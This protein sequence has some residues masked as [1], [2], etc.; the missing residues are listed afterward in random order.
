MLI[1]RETPADIPS[2]HAVVTAAF[3]APGA[4]EPAEAAL[5]GRLRAGGDRL[6]ELSLVAVGEQGQVVGHVLCTRGYAGEAPVLGLAPLAVDPGHQN[7]GVGSAL[8]HAV[9]G[10]AD[11]LGEPLVA[12]LGSPAYYG[13]F[14][15]RPSGEAGIAPPDP[16][17]APHFQVRT[18]SG[19]SPAMRG[20]F[21]YAP[22]FDGL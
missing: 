3:A 22:P 9:L 10:A 18:L 6:P 19:H 8:V 1:R 17:W 12:V 14:G 13:R 11:A 20:D 2:V 16:A 4:P 5:V 21:R 15:F 7:R